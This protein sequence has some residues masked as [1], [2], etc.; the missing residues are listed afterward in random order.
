VAAERRRILYVHP[1]SEVGGSDAGLLRM[2]AAL[3]PATTE[4]SVVLPAEGPYTAA[5]RQAGARIHLLPMMQLRTLPSPVYQARYLARFIPTVRR[6]A[7]LIRQDG[8]DLVHSNSLYCLYGAF[9]A[10]LAGRPHVWHLREIPPRI[11]VAKPALGRLVLGLSRMVMSMSDACSRELLGARW[12]DPRVRTIPEGLDL[13]RWTRDPAQRPL[14]AE[15]G[16]RPDAPLLGFVARLDPWKG[17]EVFLD[18]AARV[19][20]RFPEAAF[21]VIG[22]PPAGFEGY[23]D[24]MVAR[25][26]AHGL[27]GRLHFLGMRP[28]ETMPA[29]MGDLDVF[30]HTSVTPEPFGFVVI[31]AMAMGCAVVATRAGGPLEIIEEGVSGLLTPPGDAPALAGAMEALLAD[32]ARRRALAAGARARVEARYTLEACGAQIRAFVD[33][34]LGRT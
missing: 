1:N 30:C 31:E 23:R 15:L 3:D 4:A 21:V 26:R 18:A 5:M 25:A 34:A 28:P 19:A 14:R 12:T 11:P 6:L 33:A 20:P 29:L 7:A 24:R 9:A 17:L 2:I 16:L 22:G 8:A 32:P 13:A 10:R 27:D